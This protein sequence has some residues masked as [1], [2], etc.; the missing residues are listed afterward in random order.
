MN[1]YLSMK[2]CNTSKHLTLKWF[3]Q[4]QFD[5]VAVERVLSIQVFDYM[6]I[7]WSIWELKLILLSGYLDN[8]LKALHANTGVL[9]CCGYLDLF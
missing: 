2:K 4:G 9:N 1:K 6:E 7:N 5:L 3:A 8:V